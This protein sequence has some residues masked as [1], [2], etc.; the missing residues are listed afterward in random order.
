[1]LL[2]V[3]ARNKKGKNQISQKVYMSFQD[4]KTVF[5]SSVFFSPFFTVLNVLFN[6]ELF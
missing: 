3:L 5:V 2:L 4:C 1:M 6:A